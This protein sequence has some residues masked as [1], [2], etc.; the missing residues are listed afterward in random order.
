LDPNCCGNM[1]G[2]RFIGKLTDDRQWIEGLRQGFE[3]VQD[4]SFKKITGDSCNVA[5]AVAR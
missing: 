3:T 1:P 2:Q 4:A 5:D